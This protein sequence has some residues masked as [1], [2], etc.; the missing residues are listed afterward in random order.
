M[1]KYGH[2]GLALIFGAPIAILL[3][4]ALGPHWAF[5]T[6]L[7]SYVAASIPDIDQQISFIDHRGFTHTIWFAIIVSGFFSV[8]VTAIVSI[9]TT[10]IGSSISLSGIFL[11]NTIILVAS[12]TGFFVGFVSHLFGDILTEAYTYT[13]NPYWPVSN[14]SYTLGWTSAGSPIWNYGLLLSGLIIGFL[15]IGLVSSV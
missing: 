13:V 5:M 14:K 1:Y 10:D 9:S 4:L 6:L 8:L 11:E 7:F 15:S 2:A 12:F 3:G